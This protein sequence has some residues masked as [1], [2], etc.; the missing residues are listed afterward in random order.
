MSISADWASAIVSIMVGIVAV[1]SA[2]SSK[3]SAEAAKEAVEFQRQLYIED[4][5]ATVAIRNGNRHWPIESGYFGDGKQGVE[6]F[7]RNEG[8]AIARSIQVTL[9][10]GC[11]S[12]KPEVSTSQVTD[13]FPETMDRYMI[14]CGFDDIRA[15]ATPEKIIPGWIDVLDG[16]GKHRVRFNLVA[17]L[18]V[19]DDRFGNPRPKIEMSV[20]AVGASVE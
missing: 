9:G 17:D 15:G 7:I 6:L 5:S 18:G 19:V 16:N 3:R 1:Y 10:E 12:D 13:V 20:E 4:R 14:W 2:I 8:P 11:L